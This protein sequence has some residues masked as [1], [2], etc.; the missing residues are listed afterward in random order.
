MEKLHSRNQSSKPSKSF[1]F[2]NLVLYII[3]CQN[4]YFSLSLSVDGIP[5]FLY[6]IKISSSPLSLSLLTHATMIKS[7]PEFQSFIP[8]I[9]LH[10]MTL[11]FSLYNLIICFSIFL[12]LALNHFSSALTF[13]ILSLSPISLLSR[14]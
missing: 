13:R 1:T 11:L 9:P 5:S 3:S 2:Q 14:S 7:F 4:S 6:R 8:P 10:P 12:P